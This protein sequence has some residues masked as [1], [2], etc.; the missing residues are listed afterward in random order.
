MGRTPMLPENMALICVCVVGVLGLTT[1]AALAGFAAERPWL[2]ERSSWSETVEGKNGLRG[3]WAVGNSR[4]FGI[5]GAENPITTIHQITGPHIMLASTMNNAAAFGPARLRLTAGGQPVEFTRQ[6][7][8]RVRGTDIVV[9][10]LTAPQLTLTVLNY[11]PFDVHALLRTVVVTNTAAAPLKDIVL[12]AE[13]GRTVVKD[14][15]LYDSF[16]GD[17]GG[18][19]LG[20]TRQLFSSFLEGAET[21]SNE[22]KLGTLTAKLGDLAPGAE[23][24]RTQYLIFSM[25]ETPDEPATL[26]VVKREGVN[27]LRKTYDDW[28]GW[29]ST[30]ARVACPDQKLVDLLDDTKIIVKIQTAEPQGAAGPMEFF[31][32]MWVRDSN[33]PFLYYLRMGDF[34]AARKM[35]EFYYRASAYNKVIGNLEP[36]DIDLSPP[37]P[38]DYDWTA[39]T[40]D[41]VEIPSWLVMQHAR[42]YQFTG[43]LTPIREHWGY[44]RKCVLG[45]LTNDKGEP[46]HTV[47]Y[48]S[49]EP[50][51][52]TLYRFPHHG[53]ET[54]IY[55]GFE[56]LN[57]ELFAEPCD[58][59]HWD[60]Y[61]CDSTWEF[62]SAAEAVAGFAKLLGKT[63]DAAE[64]TKI[65]ADARAACERDYWLPERGLYAPAMNMRS[66]DVHQPPFAMVNF[67]ALWIDYLKPDDPRAISNVLETMK[68]TLNPNYTTDATETLRVY[69]GMQPGMFLYNLAAIH[70]PFADP[71]LRALVEVASPSG[72]YTEKHVTDPKSYQSAFLGHRIRPWEG[73]INAD[74][75]YYYLTGLKPDMANGRIALCPRLARDW[76]ELAVSGQKLG[77]G[78]LDL[79]VNDA[80]TSRTYKLRWTG[81]K[82]LAVDFTIALPQAKLTAVKVGSAAASVTPKDQWAVTTAPL[83]LTLTPNQETTVVVEYAAE[84][85][86]LPRIARERYQY[87]L[88]RD[89]PSYQLILWD[90]EPRQA[91][92]KDLRT[93]D[94][95]KGKVNYRLISSF[96]PASPQWLRPFLLKADGTLN[97]PVLL[98]DANCVAASLK[99]AKW[100]GDP[101]LTRLLTQFMEAGGALVAVRTGETTSEFFGGLLGDAKYLMAPIDA[102]P[103]TPTDG[104]GV[105][106]F[107]LLGLPAGEK[108]VQSPAAFIYEKMVV[109]AR[110]GG[111]GATGAMLARKVGQGFFLTT[112]A[113][114]SY[115]Q[116]GAVAQNLATP[117]KLAELNRLIA[118]A[119]PE[120]VPGA[121]Q[122]FSQNNA[123]SDN[124]QSYEE[125]SAALP[126]WLPLYGKWKIAG[127]EYQQL[128]TNGYDFLATANARITGDD[129]VAV[130]LKLIEGILEG[131]SVFNLPSRFNKGASQMVR[132]CGHEALWCGPFN[133]GGG[134]SLE[135]D[136]KN[137]LP[138]R[139]SAWH[140]LK[141]IVHNSQGTYDLAVDDKPAA[142]GLKLTNVPKGGAYIG[143]VAC[144]G[145]VAFG[146]VTVTPR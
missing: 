76:K 118:A 134:F 46:V 136:L 73:G 38:P 40:N 140:T 72:E 74:A 1:S 120:S 59:P 49:I 81:S 97:A 109:L 135:H 111:Q 33:G 68:Y 25:A 48:G 13:L 146:Q 143:L 92:A 8:S 88:P 142:T 132:F 6:T 4:V 141:I 123:F 94:Y 138:A 54:W 89:V 80:G 41:R 100:W 110:P 28:R 96:N 101:E 104:A 29:L 113:N 75:A 95:L 79:H 27:L 112:L 45:Q 50:G 23:A 14:G 15:R 128:V 69:V 21:A 124:F 52:N 91:G 3:W 67:N 82:P 122:D 20:Q 105:Q 30:T 137:V 12:T 5:V 56:V 144:R 58:H 31:A 131:G 145:S 36:M 57:S 10:E 34:A 114:L 9:M 65:A 93:Y 43:D 85:T 35:L 37:V 42:Y 125:G 108:P 22:Q 139:D 126:V 62:V 90:S 103:V 106:T 51:P 61:S 19:A 78:Q 117:A 99:Y 119:Q 63:A 77:D 26:D 83:A 102:S 71:A 70:H 2:T 39:A 17:T 115:E 47:N 53:D 32:G 44:L 133:A 11:A 16:K 107:N 24:V 60:A 87:V 66:L 64:L 18:H 55:P 121:F 86:E 129:E 130:R 7:L 84:P 116:L 98:M 127:H